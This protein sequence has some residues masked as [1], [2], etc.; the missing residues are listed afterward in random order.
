MQSTNNNQSKVAVLELSEYSR[1]LLEQAMLDVAAVGGP[2]TINAQ[3]LVEDWTQQ[4]V[5]AMSSEELKYLESYRHGGLCA[6]VFANLPVPKNIMS[7]PP[8][9]PA[10]D[11][12]T[13]DKAVLQLASRSQVIL[14]LL[15]EK[16]FAYDIDNHGK[17]V[18]LVGN[19]E[20]GGVAQL[21]H[22]NSESS[23]PLSSHAGVALGAH[24]EAP[25]YSTKKAVDGHSPAPSTLILTA[26]WNKSNEPTSVLPL[27]DILNQLSSREVDGLKLPEFGFTRSDT[28]TCEKATGVNHTA[29]LTQGKYGFEFRF[30]A[31]RTF[32]EVDASVEAIHSLDALFRVINT[33]VAHKI[34]LQPNT[35]LAI[36]NAKALHGRDA[37]VDN[38]R[39]LVRLFGYHED[40]VP[41][42]LR[43]NPLLVK[44]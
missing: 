19:F 34:V 7:P 18:R 28:F 43:T 39:L 15:R 9:L 8:H 29:L 6:L 32:A 5:Q 16:A 24:T 11:T 40:S 30:N 12:L 2:D 22:E 14:S 21:P 10:I 1:Y 13:N 35:A 4:L 23:V 20:G 42:T 17:I 33:A 41:V 25:Y 31:Y 37:I 27:I 44:G 38:S 36:N 26:K 3:K